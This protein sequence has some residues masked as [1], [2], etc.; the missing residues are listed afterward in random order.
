MKKRH[1]IV[2]REKS[3]RLC[4]RLF[5]SFAVPWTSR[6]EETRHPSPPTHDIRRGRGLTFYRSIITREAP[7]LRAF[8]NLEDL[9]FFRKR[10]NARR[11]FY[12]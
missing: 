5:A 9:D 12:G 8:G 6:P 11:S 7:V 3:L 10:S 1:G 2:I 4:G